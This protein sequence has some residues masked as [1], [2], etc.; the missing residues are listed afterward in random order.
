MQRPVKEPLEKIV[1]ADIEPYFLSEEEFAR[2]E[3]FPYYINPLAFHTY[4]EHEIV[5][6]ISELGWTPPDDTDPNS[7]NCLLNCYAN[8]VHKRQF[9][10]NPYA[11]ELAGLVRQGLLG[12]D[13][14][15][16]R[17]SEPED[18]G[19]LHSIESRLRITEPLLQRQET[20]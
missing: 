12:R 4:D 16:A 6:V 15:V 10:F 2:G 20:R 8:A 7:T 1:G 14:A 17:L 18:E 3:E 11:F 19:M 13:D 9:G 5:S